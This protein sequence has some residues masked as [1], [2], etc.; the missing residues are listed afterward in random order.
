MFARNQFESFSARPFARPVSALVG[1]VASRSCSITPQQTFYL[2]PLPRSSQ[3]VRNALNPIAFKSLNFHTHAYSFAATP[4]LSILSQKHTGGIYPHPIST[5][6][7]YNHRA[8]R[9]RLTLN[10]P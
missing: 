6:A 3:R 8:L 10:C 5:Q 9:F 4:V 2:Q 7:P 1:S